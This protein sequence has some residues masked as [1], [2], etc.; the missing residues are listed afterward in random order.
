MKLRSLSFLTIGLSLFQATL[1]A[2]QTPDSRNS[3]QSSGSRGGGGG[4]G[5]NSPQI[6]GSAH[7]GQEMQNPITAGD[8]SWMISGALNQPGNSKWDAHTVQFNT[9]LYPTY[10]GGWISDD[11]R[12]SGLTLTPADDALR[13]HLKL[14]SGQG[15]VVAGLNPHSSAG[16]SGIQ[17]ND[18][19]L[20]L[21][22]TPLSKPEDLEK[23]LKSVGE[24]PVTLQLLRAGKTT[25]IQIQPLIQVTFRS[26]PPKPPEMPFW[27]GLS[28][29]AVDPTLRAQ[30]QLP[31]RQGLIV[32]EVIKDSPASKAEIKVNDILF[33]ID[34]KPMTDSAKL[35]DAVQS[36][37]E[38]PMVLHFIREGKKHWSVEV[39]PERRK[40]AELDAAAQ[41][42]Y[43][44]LVVTHPG[45][46]VND[47]TDDSKLATKSEF[48]FYDRSNDT[49]SMT[50]NIQTDHP[51][52]PADA[53]AGVSKRLDA[54]DADI[55]QLRQAIEE[56]SK[57]T[58]EKK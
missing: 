40:A 14:P 13:A 4:S 29:S 46:V 54:L 25:K 18:V 28:V 39:T 36:H 41:H 38:K 21:G 12:T 50:P 17:L 33:E 51:S 32:N 22:E 34:G 43:Q 52:R 7:R 3:S 44:A 15:L 11:V 35:V 2:G 6:S 24:K 8:H 30:L 48:L 23:Q 10:L 55:K 45:A 9:P 37:A 1:A 57:A 16:Q 53:A 31:D 47:E 26:V 56:L 42:L 19:L 58:K 5:R 27:I 49:I 20:T